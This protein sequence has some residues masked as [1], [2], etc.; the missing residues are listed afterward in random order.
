MRVLNNNGSVNN[1]EENAV[2]QV[3]EDSAMQNKPVSPIIKLLMSAGVVALLAAFI[4]ALF[5][6]MNNSGV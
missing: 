4:Y 1:I 6:F 2:E 3:V 5:Y